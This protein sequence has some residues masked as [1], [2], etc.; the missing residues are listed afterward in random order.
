M[1]IPNNPKIYW[2]RRLRRSPSGLPWKKWERGV[3]IELARASAYPGQHQCA[4]SHF[5]CARVYSGIRQGAD[6]CCGRV[7][8]SSTGMRS[9]PHGWKVTEGCCGRVRS[10]STWMRSSP[11]G[12]KG[13]VV[14]TCT[15]AQLSCARAHFLKIR[16]FN[17]FASKLQ[18]FSQWHAK[19]QN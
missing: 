15:R 2:K 4:R 19:H 10:S 7:C 6:G 8:S 9:S 1:K 17:L 12:W 18:F 3:F 5:R 13:V 11:F 16:I 14:G